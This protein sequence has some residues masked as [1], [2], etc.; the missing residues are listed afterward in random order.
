METLIWLQAILVGI[1]ATLIMD[2]WAWLQKNIFSIPSLDY[3][4]VARWVALIPKGQ[5]IHRPIMATP[6]VRGEKLLGWILH[7]LIGI[8]FA[9]IHVFILGEAWLI[10]PSMAP[11]LLTGVV[12]MVFPF[13]II[14]PCLGFGFAASKT[15]SPWKARWLSLLAHSVYGVGLFGAALVLKFLI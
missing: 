1:G 11:A 4:L 12:T 3:A 5:L 13:C 15:P 6:A 10:D 9:L 14:Q 8:V 2:A 7:Y